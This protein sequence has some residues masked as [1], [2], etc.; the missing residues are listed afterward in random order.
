MFVQ[1]TSQHQSEDDGDA[2]LVAAC[3]T[4]RIVS[5]S[6][7]FFPTIFSEVHVKFFHCSTNTVPVGFVSSVSQSLFSGSSFDVVFAPIS[8]CVLKLS[9]PVPLHSFA[10]RK[11]SKHIKKECA[12]RG[13][14]CAFCCAFLLPCAVSPLK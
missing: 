6:I 12:F 2:F 14:V 3:N 7:S 1:S 4:M 9:N 10:E 11:Q 13:G 8:G 5:K